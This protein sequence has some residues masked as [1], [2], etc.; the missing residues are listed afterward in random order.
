MDNPDHSDNGFGSV[1]DPRPA[2]ESAPPSGEDQ[3]PGLVTGQPK[4]SGI[5]GVADM[6][7]GSSG[8]GFNPGH[9]L[10]V[11]PADI[12]E[13]GPRARITDKQA[14]RWP[15]IISL[16]LRMRNGRSD[17]VQDL[18]VSAYLSV[19]VGGEARKELIEVATGQMARRFEAG[20]PLRNRFSSDAKPTGAA[21]TPTGG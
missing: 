10:V 8:G 16:A 14:V 3:A 4:A 7:V 12:S 13:W 15:R 2:V 6:L 1:P 9:E 17:P 5:P 19:A 21:S 20:V 18:A 11:M